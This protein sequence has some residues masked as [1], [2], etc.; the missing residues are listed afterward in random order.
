M[1]QPD[2]RHVRHNAFTGRL[3]ASPKD[4]GHPCRSSIPQVQDRI[5]S[6]HKLGSHMVDAI[7]IDPVTSDAGG[8]KGAVGEVEDCRV[9]IAG[10][11]T[12]FS[13]ARFSVLGQGWGNPEQQDHQT[14]AH[15]GSFHLSIPFLGCRRPAPPVGRIERAT[16][17][18]KLD[19]FHGSR[20][21]HLANRT[22]PLSVKIEKSVTLPQ[23]KR[24][25]GGFAAR[26][27]SLFALVPVT[28]R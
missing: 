17:S 10:P 11:A 8:P 4:L 26:R 15:E 21:D 14:G 20:D 5:A 2:L 3:A 1:V 18:P 19:S 24:P 25:V 7:L 27:R 16:I 23:K 12:A 9:G 22:C 6:R 28:P 13:F